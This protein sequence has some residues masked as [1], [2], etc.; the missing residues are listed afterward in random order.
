MTDADHVFILV[1]NDSEID[2]VR[3][4]AIMLGKTVTNIVHDFVMEEAERTIE[5]G[6]MCSR[7]ARQDMSRARTYDDDDRSEKDAMWEGI[8]N[9]SYFM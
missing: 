8:Q 7:M 9:R 1:L 2:I 5:D 6:E 4:A 3:R